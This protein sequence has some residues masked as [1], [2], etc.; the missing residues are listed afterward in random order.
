M[1]L[2]PILTCF[3]AAEHR[4]LRNCAPCLHVAITTGTDR[5]LRR[6]RNVI[7]KPVNALLTASHLS[8]VANSIRPEQV[9][10]GWRCPQIILLS[11]CPKLLWS[12][13]PSPAFTLIAIISPISQFDVI[14]GETGKSKRI[15]GALENVRWQS[16][17]FESRKWLGKIG[18]GIIGS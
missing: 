7:C 3:F 17:K 10:D 15:S 2:F 1:Y 14:S 11:L 5:G 4:L 6:S 9:S 12:S 18:Q 8:K 13:L 16:W